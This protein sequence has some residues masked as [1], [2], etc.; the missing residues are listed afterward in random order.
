MIGETL[1]HY[2][3][4]EKLGKGGMGEVY[5]AEDTTL[6]RKVALKVLPPELAT[7]QERLERFQREA[8]SLASLNHPNIVT[9]HTVEE[10]GGVRFLTM[11]WVEGQTLAELV[12]KGGMPLERIFE[13]ATPLADALAV[14]HAKGV[15]HRDLKPGNVMVTED[16]R[17]KVLDFGLAKLLEEEPDLV[18]TEMATEALTR[19]GIAMGTIPYMSPEQVQGKAVDHRS[20]I[21]SLGIVLYEMSTGQLPFEG[22]TS[23]DLISSILRE[24]PDSVT[25]LRLELPRH[26]GRIIR[27]CL[28]KDPQRRYQSALDVRNEIEGLQKEVES[29]EVPVSSM[30]A[31]TPVA[32]PGG[33]RKWL[34]PLALAAIVVIAGGVIWRLGGKSETEMTHTAAAPA[35][36]GRQ[37]MVVLPFENLGA[38]EDEYFAAGMTE[39]ITTRLAAVSGLGVISRK[40][41]MQYAGTDKTIEQIGEE[42][43]VQY[44]LEGTV[45]WAKTDDGSRVRISPQLIRVADD[46]HLW[47]DTYDRVIDDVFE[48]QSDIAGEVI[49][50]LG[51]TLLEPEQASVEARPTENMEAYQAYLRGL[52]QTG[53]LTYS[54]EDRMIEIEMFER[55][56]ELDPEFA[57]AWAELSMAHSGLINLGMDKSP[58]RLELAKEAV[59]RAL[60][61]D[62]DLPEAHLAMAYYYYWGQRDYEP[63]LEALAI[64]EQ[65][66]PEDQDVLIAKFAI[67][68]RQG[69]LDKSLEYVQR[70]FELSPLE[71]DL[72]REI[73]VIHALERHYEK[74]FESLDR[75]IALAPDQQAAYF[76]KAI[77][78]WALGDVEQARANLDRAPQ[79]PGSFLTFFNT[80][81]SFM[82][83][84]W[85]QALAILDESP[86]DTF[87]APDEWTLI[88]QLRG[89]LFSQLG[90][91]DK[92]RQ[93]FE[94]ALVRADEQLEVTPRDA[95]VHSTRGLI[96]ASLGR[97]EEA[98]ADGREAVRLYPPER[99]ALHGPTHI[100]QLARIYTRVGEYDKALG[101]LDRLL[102]IPSVYSP[103][104]FDIDPNYDAL[105]NH[106]S[107]ETVLGRYRTK[108]D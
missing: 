22:E 42:L 29:G 91:E 40:S 12:E 8:E 49:N 92:A 53:H 68:R 48:V 6:K 24:N 95:R 63:A 59:D 21:F 38:A 30:S 71:D 3:I 19:E 107:Y 52:D 34:A 105:R 35:E 98:I 25:D 78:Y 89:E 54:E 61:L 28:E 44:V 82:E 94:A 57:L 31:A 84:D 56:V 23:A 10:D 60:E 104:W 15:V 88:E 4:L 75:S 100:E 2:R 1:S 69:Q 7:S 85:E 83:R 96:L 106:S 99:D 14:A 87:E 41:A 9:I 55:S 77:Y 17:V 74:A 101:Q 33:S 37:M 50:Q 32:G 58:E 39:E 97:K 47:A 18:A 79:T 62:P 76:F 16:G 70:A 67:L 90:D 43:R 108:T 20:D 66:M 81:Q 36:V 11:E 86:V 102:S 26:F 65:S 13:I 45:R 103:G 73:A 80:G 64:A 72:P 93:A 5:L 51:V 27:H 46:T